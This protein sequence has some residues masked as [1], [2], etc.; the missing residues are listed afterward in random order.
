MIIIFCVCHFSV[1]ARRRC[2]FLWTIDNAMWSDDLIACKWQLFFDGNEEC[3]QAICARHSCVKFCCVLVTV[4]VWV[5]C[6]YKSVQ[7]SHSGEWK[8]HSCSLWHCLAIHRKRSTYECS[9]RFFFADC[10]IIVQAHLKSTHMIP[11]KC[12]CVSLDEWVGQEMRSYYFYIFRWKNCW[13]GNALNARNVHTAQSKR[14]IFIFV[15]NIFSSS[16]SSLW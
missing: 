10:S 9:N 8:H 1:C 5:L 11:M 7:I 2:H 3:R 4:I 13:R 12:V 14:S 15:G 6:V 16:S